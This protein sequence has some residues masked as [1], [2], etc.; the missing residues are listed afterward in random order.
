[1]NRDW[2]L[3]ETLGPT[4]VV[5]AQGWQLRKMVP[6]STYLRRNS[7]LSSI[8]AAVAETMRKGEGLSLRSSGV[9]RALC[10]R[11]VVM[12]DGRIHGVQL[13]TG[14][15]V[16]APPPPP[17]IGATV[18]N[19]TTGIASDT[20]EALL[21]SGLDPQ[22]LSGRCFADDLSIRDLHHEE[23]DALALTMTAQPGDSLCTTWNVT[24]RDG[25]PIRV[26]FSSRAVAQVSETGG[27]ELVLRAMNWRV[28]QAADDA[29]RAGSLAQSIIR[30]MARPGEHRIL[31]RLDSWT[32]LK[33]LDEPYPRV[34]WRGEFSDKPLIHPEDAAVVSSMQRQFAQGPATEVLR[35]RGRSRGWTFVHL[36]VRHLPLGPDT[37]AG[38]V[39]VR[40]PSPLEMAPF[41]HPDLR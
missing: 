30:A 33:W 2:L 12:T 36:T 23:G 26:A 6:L 38:L 9:Q 25:Q 19:L 39:S 40:L 16:D 21:N 11:P 32:L 8:T 34:D 4:P 1:M 7:M 5:V 13:W 10:T 41:A 31:V 17:R 14:S 20:P 22:P 3:V 37:N 24:A 35:F 15:R 28:P 18:W 29:A 27:N